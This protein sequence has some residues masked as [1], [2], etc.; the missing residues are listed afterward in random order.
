MPKNILLYG[1]GDDFASFIRMKKEY[2]DLFKDNI[3]GV[4]DSS[5]QKVGIVKCGYKIKIFNE[6]KNIDWDIV[7]ITSSNYATEIRDKLISEYGVNDNCIY[8]LNDYK[9]SRII[10]YQYNRN[11]KRI[12]YHRNKFSSESLVVYTGVFGSYDELKDPLVVDPGVHYICYTDQDNI[13]SSVWEIRKVKENKLPAD[14]L[15]RKI[16]LLPHE[17]L[18][19]FKTS[20]WIDASF[21]ITRSLIELINKYQYQSDILLFPHFDRICIYD[22]AAACMLLHKEN[23]EKIIRQVME[24]YKQGYPINNGLYCGGFIVRNHNV[25]KIKKTMEAWY[26]QVKEYSCRDQISLPY[27]LFRESVPVDLFDMNIYD[28]E[29]IRYCKHI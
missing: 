23:K 6:F 2:K 27:V 21:Q 26:K 17:Y 24:Y 12:G 25:S 22:E 28:N 11:H 29:W 7:V 8:N 10:E 19:E 15:T 4:V 14:I 20:I 9:T 5:P 3:V 16:K 13:E 1:A 18:N